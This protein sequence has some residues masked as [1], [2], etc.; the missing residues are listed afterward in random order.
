[1]AT[2]TAIIDGTGS[3]GAAIGP[4]LAGLLTAHYDWSSVIYMV[5]ISEAFAILLLVRLV[6]QEFEP[7][8]RNVRIE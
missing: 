4:L 3:F 1:M 7:L 6:K 5:A 2:V 8:R